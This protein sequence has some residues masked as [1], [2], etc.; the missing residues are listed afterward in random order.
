MRIQPPE[1]SCEGGTS[2]EIGLAKKA[3]ELEFPA[4]RVRPGYLKHR[5][6]NYC[7]SGQNR[8]SPSLDAN[9]E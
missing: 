6:I 7:R 8:A 4:P 5:G 1:M 2:E 3:I 9:F